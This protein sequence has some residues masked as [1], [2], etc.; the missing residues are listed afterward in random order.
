MPISPQK[1]VFE[2]IKKAT[3]LNLRPSF[4]VQWSQLVRTFNKT[5]RIL[6]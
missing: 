3:A 5:V 4:A 6:T 1:W 2:N